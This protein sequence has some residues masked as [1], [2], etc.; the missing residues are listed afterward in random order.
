M[1][2]SGELEAS[3]ASS[4]SVQQADSARNKRTMP[5]DRQVEIGQMS[6]RTDSSSF[7]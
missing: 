3:F 4:Y 6:L 7:R 5:W 1:I 2:S